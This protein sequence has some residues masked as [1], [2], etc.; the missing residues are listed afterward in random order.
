M[1]EVHI[2]SVSMIPQVENQIRVALGKL[3]E[4]VSQSK[5]QE[6]QSDCMAKLTLDAMRVIDGAAGLLSDD[7]NY[8]S[9]ASPPT[10]DNLV[11]R[12]ES[13]DEEY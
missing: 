13:S 2:E 9:T 8:S 7:I 10:D 5:V 12:D 1:S 3:R 6:N 4:L 11:N